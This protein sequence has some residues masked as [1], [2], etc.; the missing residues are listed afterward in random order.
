MKMNLAQDAILK[1]VNS[2]I[3]SDNVVGE[4]TKLITTGLISN[5]AYIAGT[6][7]T[8]IAA[9]IQNAVCFPLIH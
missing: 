3:P 5:T 7:I 2:A 8:G 1:I 6:T 4:L 9:A